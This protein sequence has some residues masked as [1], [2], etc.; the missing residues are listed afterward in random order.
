M[1]FVLFDNIDIRDTLYHG[2]YAVQGIYGE[3]ILRVLNRLFSIFM[4]LPR[5]LFFNP[6]IIIIIIIIISTREVAPSAKAGINGEPQ[7]QVTV[8]DNRLK[9]GK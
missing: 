9:I 5:L 7:I 8:N 2:L 6:T 4:H 1:L 3:I